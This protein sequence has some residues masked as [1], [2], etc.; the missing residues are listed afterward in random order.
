LIFP[1][2]QTITVYRPGGMDAFG[3]PQPGDTHDVGP[4]AVWQ[5]ASTEH[6]DMRDTVVTTRTMLVPNGADIVATD[7]VYL[8]GDDQGKPARWQ[9]SGDPHRWH[10]PLT[11]WEP[12]TE[13]QLERVTG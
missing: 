3:D 6:T 11:G 2:G 1:F 13:V 9:V 5:T 12:G 8:P 4:C 10:S 7:R